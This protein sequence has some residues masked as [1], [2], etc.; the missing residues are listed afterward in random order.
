MPK[1]DSGFA[2]FCHHGIWIEWC[3]SYAERLGIINEYKPENE[4]A[5]RKRVFILI[6]ND[7]LPQEGL[8]EYYEASA[9]VN[10]ACAAFNEALDA[11][12][13]KANDALDEADDALDK[14]EAAYDEALDAYIEMNKDEFTKLYEE[15]C[16]DSPWNGKTIFTRQ[17][18][19]EVWY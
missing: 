10:K 11:A 19:D 3:Y 14:A 13:G 4:R 6:P 8:A 2:F 17:D 7:R 18:K 9:A 1:Q 15:L 16:P 12:R 5:L